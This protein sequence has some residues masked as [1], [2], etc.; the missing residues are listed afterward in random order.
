MAVEREKICKNHLLL[1]EG[2]DAMY[3][4]ISMLTSL[5]FCDDKRISEEIQVMDFGGIRDLSKFLGLL[6]LREGFS[7]VKSVLIVRDAETDAEGAIFSIKNSLQQNGLSVPDEA[8]NW[9]NG[10]PKIAYAL[11]PSLDK[12][13][14]NGALED[15]CCSLIDE[16]NREHIFEQ[17]DDFLNTM[18]LTHGFNYPRIFKNRLHTY[19]SVKN[20]FVSFK[21]GEAAKANAFDW[22]SEKLDDFRS[23]LLRAFDQ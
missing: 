15:L 20:E 23:L 4:F 19:L 21:I 10:I 14:R 9:C 12:N 2:A 17:V 8:L 18:K 11:L 1:C 6:K 13:Y 16:K 22:K 3:F 7:D 5:D